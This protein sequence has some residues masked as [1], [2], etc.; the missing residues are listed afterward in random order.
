MLSWRYRFGPQEICSSISPIKYLYKYVTKGHDRVAASVRVEKDKEQDKDEIR[1]Y[2]DARY[3]GAS[4]AVYCIFKFDLSDKYPAV[5]RLLVQLPHE[6]LIYYDP[7]D[8]KAAR[9]KVSGFS[10]RETTLTA[11]F[12][13]NKLLRNR[14]ARGDDVAALQLSYL[15][16]SCGVGRGTAKRG[17]SASR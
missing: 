3:I 11:W 17:R 16:I 12:K 6:Q 7:T 1:N 5:E 14:A 9:E 13:A 8:E 4:E 10:E 2:L 15:N